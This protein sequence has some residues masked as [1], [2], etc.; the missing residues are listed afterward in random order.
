MP[1]IGEAQKTAYEKA[2][3]HGVFAVDLRLL[4]MHNEAFKEHIDV[5]LNKDKE[6][7]HYDLFME[8]VDRLIAGEPLEYVIGE[9]TFLEHKLNVNKDV[10]IPRGETEELVS[11]ITEKI[12]KYYDP[13]NYLVA[14]DIGTGSGAIAIAL[15][16]YFPNWILLASDISPKALEVAKGNFEKNGVR[17]SAMEGDALEPY[18]KT[19]TNLD[20]IVS[21]PPYITE[22]EYVQDSVLAHE[23]KSALFLDYEDNVYLSIFRDYRKVKKGTMFLAFEISP[24]LKDYLTQL[25]KDH[26]EDYEYEFEEDLNG[27]TRFLFIYLK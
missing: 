6:M 10:L 25:M 11:K 22:G 21:N 4:I 12:G 15:K 19:N 7:K 17:V 20:I 26:L 18:I 16:S 9:T 8:Q 23:P 24:E 1:T 27:L 2:K 13:R 3:P 14:A 5:L